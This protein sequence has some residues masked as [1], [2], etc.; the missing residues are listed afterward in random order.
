MEHYQDFLQRIGGFELPELHFAEEGLVPSPGVA[1]KVAEDGRFRPFYGDT[2]VFVLSEEE[3]AAVRCMTDVLYEAAPECFCERL[4]GST[5]HMTLHDLSNSP[6]QEEVSARMRE[7]EA[8]LRALLREHPVS[9]RTIRMRSKAVFNMVGTSLVLGLIPADEEAFEAL[10]QLY[11]LVDG[12]LPLPYPLT[13]HITLGYYSPQG[14]DGA[15]ARRLEAAAGRLL[16]VP[17]DITLHTARL[18]YQHF[19]DMNSFLSENLSGMSLI[20]IFNQ[21]KKKEK[22]FDMRNNTH[23]ILKM[24]RNNLR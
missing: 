13:P 17:L 22:E 16:P 4:G 24:P 18:V 1:R 23:Q 10:M 19:S 2:V 7:N 9:P 21:E 12:V 8:A 14:F 6:V 15:A 3:K 11:R 20:Q 5:F